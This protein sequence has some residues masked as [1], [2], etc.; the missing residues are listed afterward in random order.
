M[1]IVTIVEDNRVTG[2]TYGEVEIGENIQTIKHK[3]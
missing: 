1:K 2:V 3:T